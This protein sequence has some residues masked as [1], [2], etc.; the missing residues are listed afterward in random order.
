VPLQA[1]PAFLLSTGYMLSDHSSIFAKL[2]RK[3]RL[4]FIKMPGYNA[5]KMN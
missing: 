4:T 1:L 2:P 5:L 3:V